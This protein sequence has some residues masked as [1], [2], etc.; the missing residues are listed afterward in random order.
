MNTIKTINFKWEKIDLD[1]N[2]F[3]EKASSML[4]AWAIWD[5]LWV[6]VEMKTKEYIEKNYWRVD[7]FLDSSLNI[8]FNK[9]W[10]NEWKTGLV[11]D[12]TILSFSWL[13]SITKTWKI[14]FDDILQTNSKDYKDF[15][16]WFWYWT[17]SAL[18]RYELLKELYPDFDNY[19]NL[20]DKNSAWNWVIMKQSPYVAYF[21][22]RE[23]KQEIINTNIEILTRL[24]HNHPTAVVASQVHNQFLMELLK[25]TENIDFTNL[26]KY[27]INFS[28]NRE[29][30][31]K[32]EFK[33]QK[34]D[35]ISS[36]LKK[37]LE[38]IQKWWLKTFDEILKKYWWWEQ[39][40]YASGYVLTTM[41][42]V[43]SIFLNKQNF[44]WLLDSINIGW[45]V[46][47]F[48]AIIWNMIWA[49]KWEFY[50][51]Y[52]KNWI[53]DIEN[54]ETQ[55]NKF[56]DII[57]SKKNKNNNITKTQYL[58]KLEKYNQNQEEIKEEF[59]SKI[60]KLNNSWEN[61]FYNSKWNPTA[62]KS[63]VKHLSYAET[64]KYWKI[65]NWYFIIEKPFYIADFEWFIIK[66]TILWEKIKFV[67][68]EYLK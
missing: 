58:E 55:V 51:E 20:W 50:D 10:L 3:A 13:K 15:P 36:L 39:K 19:I 56:I 6:P 66:Q 32:K 12:D 44:E 9:W 7:D 60:K 29:N 2:L 53:Q 11:S 22:A 57:L 38:D 30:E 64:L 4:I 67:K 46:D 52:Y 42:I 31:L 63:N 18:K 65:Q 27:L 47:T 48:W 1:K 41:W 45:D 68:L 59:F 49:Y 37:L 23:T 28:E 43:Y 21:L 54:L 25:S 8:F 40:I 33:E 26:L 35:K 61:I 17:T 5:A 24:T 14:D 34:A 16:Y 62:F